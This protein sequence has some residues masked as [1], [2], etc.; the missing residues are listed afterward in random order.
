MIWPTH[1]AKPLLVTRARSTGPTP[2]PTFDVVISARR[3]TAHAPPTPWFP[4]SL[5]RPPRAVL[6]RLPSPGHKVY[7]STL[8]T[9]EVCGKTGKPLQISLQANA[10][11]ARLR[12]CL[13]PGPATCP[14]GGGYAETQE[15]DQS[16]P[17]SSEE[18]N[19]R[20]STQTAQGQCPLLGLEVTSVHWGPTATR[21]CAFQISLHSL[22]S[23]TSLVSSS[24]EKEVK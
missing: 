21:L 10:C 18:Q 11:H 2:P 16:W 22:L 4:A 5:A 15:D 13:P 12:W 1:S 7:S 9:E 20:L 24:R 3:T 14:H 17:T 19:S 8:V 6:A 23:G